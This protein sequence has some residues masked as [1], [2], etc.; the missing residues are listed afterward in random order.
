MKQGA[1]SGMRN[2]LKTAHTHR[3]NEYRAQKKMRYLQTMQD[4]SSFAN[5]DILLHILHTAYGLDCGEISWDG[6]LFVE[7]V[8]TTSMQ[9][10][11]IRSLYHNFPKTFKEQSGWLQFPRAQCLMENLTGS[12]SHSERQILTLVT[13]ELL[14]KVLKHDGSIYHGIV[15]A[16][17]TYLAAIYFAASEYQEARPLCSSVLMDQTSQEDRETLNAGCL[18]F[19]DDVARI[20]GLCVLYKKITENNFHFTNRRI[21]LDLRLLPEVFAQYLTAL[22]AERMSKE[23]RFYRDLPDSSFHM[24]ANLKALIKSK[25]IFSMKSDFHSNAALVLPVNFTERNRRIVN[26]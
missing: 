5:H 21:Y 16:A 10:K 25:Y 17:L 8:N 13:K 11:T 23:S 7:L 24:D 3:N 19:I 20:V 14:K 9:A 26:C 22:S 15:P 6:S 4:V 1:R 12:N 18:L 2:S